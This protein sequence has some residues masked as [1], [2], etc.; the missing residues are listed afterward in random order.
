M[1]DHGSKP[2]VPNTSQT[3]RFFRGAS[4]GILGR[5]EGLSMAIGSRIQGLGFS[6]DLR[7]IGLED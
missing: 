2:R 1:T 5:L 4:S 3:L 7:S 6:M